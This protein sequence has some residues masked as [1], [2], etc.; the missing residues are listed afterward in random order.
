MTWVCLFDSD[1]QGTPVQSAIV[2]HAFDSRV[3]PVS[4]CNGRE[5][6]PASARRRAYSRGV[7][8]FAFITKPKAG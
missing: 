4:S 5:K 3:A 2:P 1:A 7:S 6:S 8:M